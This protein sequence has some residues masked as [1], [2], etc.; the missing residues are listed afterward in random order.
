ME[1][2]R[3]IC[4]CVEYRKDLGPGWETGDPLSQNKNLMS[5]RV[6]YTRSTHGQCFNKH[7]F[8]PKSDCLLCHRETQ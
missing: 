4:T 6:Y 8:K 5:F 7:A 1:Y 2:S 3:F